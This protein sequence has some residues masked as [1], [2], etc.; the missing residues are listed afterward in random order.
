LSG[1]ADG[2]LIQKR[3]YGYRIV[4]LAV[5]VPLFMQFLDA[6][7]LTTALPAIARDLGRPP[8]DLNVTLLS[9]QLAMTMFIPAGSA[10]GNR[11]GIRT[12]FTAALCCFLV[13]SL[14]CGLSS[15]LAE[16]VASRTIQGVGGALLMPLG[17]VIVVRAADRSELVSALNWL[18]IPA[19]VGPL[20]GPPLGGLIT[21][22][23]SWHY[24]F[25]LNLPVGMIGLVGG[26]LVI[27]KTPREAPQPFDFFGLLLV[28]PTLAALVFGLET[29]AGGNLTRALPLI[30]AAMAFGALYIWHARRT[31]GPLLD[32]DLLRTQS[33]RS[34]VVLGSLI[35]GLGT[36]CS[37][38]LPLMFQLGL[39]KSALQSGTLTFAIPVG[40]LASRLS[41]NLILKRLTVR[42]SMMIGL[43]ITILALVV[44]AMLDGRSPQWAIYAGLALFGWS[45]AM[46]LVVIGAMA[47]VD[48]PDAKAGDATGLYTTFQ[49]LSFSVGIVGGVA[50]ASAGAWMSSGDI[51]ALASY[52]I[53][54]L[55]LAAT[56]G[57]TLLLAIRLPRG[58]GEALRDSA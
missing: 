9:Y 26:L 38:L 51:H 16:L 18:L 35:R 40:A 47:Y 34:S 48:V 43:G 54:F 39:G 7:V 22:Y 33:F 32:L 19:I 20:V 42:L 24:I 17:R 14:L 25:Y 23:A 41:S 46:A 36:A 49:Q 58:I 37:F 50:A 8:L 1:L 27:P 10:L 6:T 13:G 12:M 5:S 11:F 44:F 45:S 29:A 15:S 30:V 2:A 57:V 52:S 55:L 4:A 3:P 28:T 56:A 31:N 21:S 53:G